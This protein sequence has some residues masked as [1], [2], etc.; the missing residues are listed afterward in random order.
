MEKNP[1][2]HCLDSN[3]PLKTSSSL[4]QSSRKSHL[5]EG[6]VRAVSYHK[7]SRFA[8]FPFIGDINKCFKPNLEQLV[9]QKLLEHKEDVL[10]GAITK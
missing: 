2:L 8:S 9:F 1:P 6:N 5:V 3:N 7:A 10:F 4:N